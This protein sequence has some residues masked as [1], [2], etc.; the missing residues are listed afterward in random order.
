[1][2]KIESFMPADGAG[3]EYFSSFCI[4]IADEFE[5]QV[6]V[7]HH[8]SLPDSLLQENRISRSKTV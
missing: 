6:K 4:E 3:L 7:A 5:R 8:K 1:L 2:K